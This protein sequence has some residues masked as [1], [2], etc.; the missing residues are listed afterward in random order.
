MQIGAFLLPIGDTALT[1]TETEERALFE[2]TPDKGECLEGLG[3]SGP[4]ESMDNEGNEDDEKMIEA[5]AMT[6]LQKKLSKR[7]SIEDK[8]ANRC[9]EM[10]WYGGIGQEL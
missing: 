10:V 8:V 6:T 7:A 1:L 4:S 3:S 5:A 2:K 9:I